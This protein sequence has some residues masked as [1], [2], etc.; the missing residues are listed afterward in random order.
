MD[1][2]AAILVL[3]SVYA[4]LQFVVIPL[5]SSAWAANRTLEKI[6]KAGILAA[7]RFARTLCQVGFVVYGLLYLGLRFWLP[8]SETDSAYALLAAIDA[9]QNLKSV[10]ATFNEHVWGP[11]LLSVAIAGLAYFAWRR[12]KQH[13]VERFNDQ[14]QRELSRLQASR[15]A[16][17]WEMLPPT[18]EMLVV[19]RQIALTREAMAKV[20]PE[21]RSQVM[22]LLHHLEQYWVRLDAVRRM[23]LSL[24]P[25]P[26]SS[27][28][29]RPLWPGLIAV[30]WSKGLQRDVGLIGKTLSRASIAILALLLIGAGLPVVERS[31]STR[32]DELWTLEVKKDQEEARSK[33]TTIKKKVVAEAGDGQLSASDDQ[34]LQGIARLFTRA[35]INDGAGG[36]VA[37]SADAAAGRVRYAIVRQAIL[38]ET[39]QAQPAGSRGEVIVGKTGVQEPDALARELGDRLAGTRETRQNGVAGRAHAELRDIATKSSSLRKVFRDQWAAHLKAYGAPAATM[40]FAKTVFGEAIDFAVDS[41]VDI[42]ATEPSGVLGK[43]AKKLAEKTLSASAARAYE[44]SLSRFVAAMAGKST[45]DEAIAAISKQ[46]APPYT[47]NERIAIATA[48]REID[49]LEGQI[50]RAL[51]DHPPRIVAR[52][53]VRSQGERK[54]LDHIQKLQLANSRHDPAR[55][56]EFLAKYDDHF[57]PHS[58]PR[59]DSEYWNA[60]QP[61]LQA[62]SSVAPNRPTRLEQ[63]KQNFQRAQSY[64]RLKGYARVG[65]VLIG[66]S[67]KGE[68]QLDFNGF[69]Y[70][71][72]SGRTTFALTRADGAKFKLG[73]YRDSLVH[74]A[75]GYAADSRPVA[76]TMTRALPLLDLRIL[77]HP[78]LE[79]TALGCR[80]IKLDQMVD[81]VTSCRNPQGCD[82]PRSRAEMEVERQMILYR[83]AW[84]RRKVIL[85]KA[86]PLDGVSADRAVAE[87]LAQIKNY[88][89]IA[90]PVLRNPQALLDRK[91]SILAAKQEYFQP[92]LLV[93]LLRCVAQ[94]KGEVGEFDECLGSTF[95]EALENL[96]ETEGRKWT[97][98]PPGHQPLSGVRERPYRADANLDFLR[99]R[100]ADTAE[101]KLWPFNFILQ[102]AFDEGG[103]DANPWEFPVLDGYIESSVA[104]Y[105]SGEGG[106]QDATVVRDVREF[107]LLQRFFRLA[108][109][110]GFG[111]AFPVERLVELTKETRLPS[112]LHV[113]T[114]RWLPKW[115]PDSLFRSRLEGKEHELN[116]AIRYFRR[117]GNARGV[118]V[119]ESLRTPVARC[120]SVI[121][122]SARVVNEGAW[123]QSCSRQAFVGSLST[124][125]DRRKEA[126]SIDM[127]MA[128]EME[129]LGDLAA[130]AEQ[131][132]NLRAALRVEADFD[133]HESPGS[134]LGQCPT[135]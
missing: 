18:E 64:A 14:V 102:V 45:L 86:Y 80:M 49:G 134:A 58:T 81:K 42:A 84:L 41:A 106:R 91:T 13:L 101:G 110:G 93:P 113:K 44:I 20:E 133:W 128:C 89:E 70:L 59:P 61:L 71:R 85:R 68:V 36:H 94:A 8:H 132:R 25:D 1:L 126:E 43:Q 16:G 82:D 35:L 10:L 56:V 4:T 38:R 125:C 66:D 31:V 12:D 37:S 104:A 34:A 26:E 105:L 99:D 22:E 52:R 29:L 72:S 92:D 127:H 3:G 67:P 75:L 65:G 62:P 98:P 116:Q 32:I 122:V 53:E 9:A 112:S 124:K 77:L 109:S 55:A 79:D 117:R 19:E 123:H 107:V 100:P 119:Y 96:D 17:E 54:V 90:A 114:P 111:S 2:S 130:Q 27:G 73:P 83:Y 57:L 11:L 88:G 97:R 5:A 60:L 103:D 78:V 51:S 28:S 121:K 24:N 129:S 7:L 50:H 95:Q 108:L 87:D 135:M 63:P 23:D 131:L 74:L 76:V 39:V 33:L 115:T 46:R 40:D 30:L 120:L 69:R 21:R 47:P 15:D 48:F 118:S 6:G